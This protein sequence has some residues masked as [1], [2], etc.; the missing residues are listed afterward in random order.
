VSTADAAAGEGPDIPEKSWVN[1]FDEE[2]PLHDLFEEVV[3]ESRDLIMVVDDYYARRGTGKTI[4][5]MQL[6]AGMDQTDEGLTKAKV[7]L[8]PEEIRNAYASQ[9]KRSGLVLDEGEFGASNR[10]A[11]SKT[12]QAL[13]EI[14]SMGRVEEKYVVVNTPSKSFL[15]K[16]ILT[17][18]DVWISMV[19]KG[20]GLVHFLEYEPYS[21]QRLTPSK[22]WIEVDDIER[23]TD[24]RSVYNYLTSEKRKR[25]QGDEGEGF[26][27]RSEHQEELQQA[28]KQARKDAR[29]E[30]VR[31]IMAHPEIQEG[32]VSQR[33]VGEAIGVSQATVSR[34]LEETPDE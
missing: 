19:R 9:P 32:Q 15:D 34:I 27:Q 30:F 18:C 2:T 12:N 16:D 14:M 31:G 5:S 29:D 13:R 20:Q 3:T 26:I 28:R 24:L 6:A 10:Q 11:M 8:Q 25:I 7:S 21:E 33:T 23:G 1:P 4:T 22:Q 17:L